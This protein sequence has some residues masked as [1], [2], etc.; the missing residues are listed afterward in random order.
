LKVS[1]YFLFGILLREA[2]FSNQEII[3][4]WFFVGLDQGALLFAMDG[5]SRKL[6]GN[7]LRPL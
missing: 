2:G 5:L 1:A 3:L 6:P 4:A 7:K